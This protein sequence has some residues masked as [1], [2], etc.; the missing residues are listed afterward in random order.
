MFFSRTTCRVYV[1][2]FPSLY[3]LYFYSLP[4]CHSFFVRSV[5]PHSCQSDRYFHGLSGGGAVLMKHPKKKKV[6]RSRANADRTSAFSFCAC[7]YILDMRPIQPV[8]HVIGL[9]DSNLPSLAKLS[10]VT[11]IL[12]FMAV[13]PITQSNRRACDPGSLPHIFFLSVSRSNLEPCVLPCVLPC[14]FCA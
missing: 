14:V 8:L 1:C 2:V 6:V 4:R 7:A 11:E 5:I 12:D 10:C 13:V 9:V 3:V